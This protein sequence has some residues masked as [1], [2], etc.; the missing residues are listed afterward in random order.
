MRIFTAGISL[1]FL[2]ALAGATVSVSSPTTGSTVSTSVH[3][4]STSTS[5]HAITRTIVYLDNKEAYNVA[6]KSVD[7]NITVSSG[8]HSIVV[9]SWDTSHTVV[10]S[11]SIHFTASGSGSGGGGTGPNAKDYTNIDQMSGWDSCD[12]CAGA[13]GDGPSAT[14]TLSQ[15]LS[16]PAM[17]GKAAQFYLKGSKA[18][19]NALWWKQLGANPNVSNFTY[20]L[21]F[22]LKTPSAAQALEF[23]V[24]Q[25]LS[26]KKYIFGT[27]CDI[28]DHHAWM[29]YDAAAHSWKTTSVACSAPAAYKWNHLT[30]EFQRSN[31]QMKFISVTL[32]GKKSY[33]N[34]TYGPA[35]SS[36]KE[37][38]VAVQIDG[39]G[40]NTP[41]SEWA[42]KITLNTY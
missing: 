12:K 7:T 23:D 10:K 4:V 29:I 28:K 27:E 3:V 35:S 22:Y 16:S 37:L 33:F 25:S 18:Y 31:G 21:Y 26:G 15:N 34:R 1:C 17:D 6:S 19:S 32:N 9:Q 5:S 41:Y 36:S 39:D 38:N 2:T 20:D 13:G 24:N 42:D 40:H 8:S 30:L 14:H 11:A